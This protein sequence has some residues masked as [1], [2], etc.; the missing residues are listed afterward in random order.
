[1]LRFLREYWIWIVTP[2]VLV[3]LAA[4]VAI[5]FFD[6]SLSPFVYPIR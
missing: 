1:M 3:L 6:D 5:V 4:I 2:L